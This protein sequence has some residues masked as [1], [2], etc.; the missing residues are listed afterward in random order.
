M[1]K[2]KKIFVFNILI[3]FLFILTL[4]LYNFFVK[5][6]LPLKDFWFPFF[7]F[8]VS[9]SLFAKFF[10][11]K[12]DSLLWF[13]LILLFFCAIMLIVELTQVDMSQFWPCFIV[14]VGIASAIVGVAYDDLM[15]ICLSVVFVF[16]GAPIFLISCNILGVW[17]FVL[18]YI[19]SLVVGFFSVNFVFNYYKKNR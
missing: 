3:G 12:S 19:V 5:N 4:I 18:A 7:L 13:A 17:W 6:F 10:L 8:C 15:Q 2:H 9:M 16:I 1:N 11:L 14:V